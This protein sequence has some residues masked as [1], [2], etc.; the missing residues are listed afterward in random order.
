MENKDIVPELLEKIKEKYKNG[1]AS[2]GLLRE[3]YDLIANKNI[4]YEDAQHAAQEIGKILS[5]AY[6][7]VF[8]QDVLPDGK[9]YYNIAERTVGT[10]M[11]QAYNDI[12]DIAEHTQNVL[13][14]NAGLGLKAIRPELNQ[15][16][17]DGI[18]NRLSTAEKYEDVAWILR[19]PIQTFCQSVIDDSVKA[20]VAFQGE[21]GLRPKIIR[22]TAGKCCEWCSRLAGTYLYPDVPKD[23]YRRHEN[24]R[25]SVTY[26]PGSGRRENVHTKQWTTSIDTATME[27]RRIIGL[28]VNRV[29]VTGVSQHTVERMAERDVTVESLKDAILHP[30]QI[31]PVKYDELGRPSFEVIGEKATIAIN[32]ETGNIVTTHKTHSKTVKKLKRRQLSDENKTG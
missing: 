19:A 15:D 24:C 11:Q 22:K 9:M 13:N 17:I 30:L 7:D 26:D 3:I 12:A 16:R 4:S 8:V 6:D 25:C 14:E 2:N 23:V 28:R 5:G 1:V 21:S 32:P 18:I 29:T 27:A 20:N 10:T 31:K